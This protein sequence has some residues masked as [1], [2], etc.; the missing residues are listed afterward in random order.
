MGSKNIL[1]Y[2]SDLFP[3]IK[4]FIAREKLNLSPEEVISL[5]YNVGFLGGIARDGVCLENVPMRTINKKK[6]Y[7][8]FVYIDKNFKLSD[9]KSIVI[10]PIFNEYL[11]INADKSLIIG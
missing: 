4:K 3:K 7:F 9:A 2:Q 11:H 5:L 10:H 1:S 6:I 8:Y